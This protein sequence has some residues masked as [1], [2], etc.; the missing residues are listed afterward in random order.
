MLSLAP[1]IELFFAWLTWPREVEMF[2]YQD[3]SRGT[4]GQLPLPPGKLIYLKMKH[5]LARSAEA[6]LAIFCTDI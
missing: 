3:T 6:P 5:G 4:L 1:A 2:S